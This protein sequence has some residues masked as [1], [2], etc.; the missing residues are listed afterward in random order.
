MVYRSIITVIV[1]LM[2]WGA[3]A[4]QDYYVVTTGRIVLKDAPNLYRTPT[5]Y[6][7]KSTILHVIGEQGDFLKIDRH[8]A[9]VWLDNR[10]DWRAFRRLE[11]APGMQAL[12]QRPAV[13]NCCSIG[14]NCGTDQKK[15]ED[16]YHAYQEALCGDVANIDNCCWAGW[17]CNSYADWERGFNAFLNDRTCSAPAPQTPVSTGRSVSA[18]PGDSVTVTYKTNLRASYSL[19]S[20]IVTT[21]ARWHDPAVFWAART[22]GS[23]S[24]GAA[25]RHG[26]QI[27]CR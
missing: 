20:R 2:V 12:S 10:P 27:G 18:A 13:D 3:A 6:V 7:P 22:T 19:Q 21:V 14:W 16:G 15:W 5:E 4:A 11:N 24:P 9:I 8:G 25:T 26:W 1:L 17:S 23:R